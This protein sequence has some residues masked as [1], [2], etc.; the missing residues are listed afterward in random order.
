MKKQTFFQLAFV[1]LT[2]GYYQISYAQIS[3]GVR[4]GVSLNNLK[5]EPLEEGEPE[6]QSVIG[7]QVAIPVEIAIGDMF[8]VQPEIMYGSHGAKQEDN[9]TATEGGFVSTVDYKAEYKINTLEIPLLA[10]LKLGS[11]KLKF[12]VLAGPSF[13]FGLSGLSKVK[14][15]LK[16]TDSNGNIFLENSSDD[17]FDA[18]F[19]AEGYDANDVD[20]DEFAV[21]KTKINLHMGAGIGFDLGGPTIFLDARYILGLSDLAPEVDGTS[22]DD[23]TSI[24]SNRLGLNVGVMFPLN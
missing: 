21:T 7:F 12:H 5:V 11:E 1:L 8:A 18:K 16:I 13:G 14:S 22:K 4:G 3:V 15:N 17:S 2:L 23:A 19:V 6:P 24:K 20:N 10:K 9:S